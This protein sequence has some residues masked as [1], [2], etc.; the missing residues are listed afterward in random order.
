MQLNVNKHF[1]LG[2]KRK[3][4]RGNRV[5]HQHKS[6]SN[7]EFVQKGKPTACQ[8][9]CDHL[10]SHGGVQELAPEQPL[11]QRESSVPG[12][13]VVPLTLRLWVA[14]IAASHIYWHRGLRLQKDF[15][16]DFRCK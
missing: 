3:K 4:K 14:L 12:S 11:L 16:A 2:N 1:M 8:P 15:T 7:S 13:P 6:C 9:Q 5:I 10:A